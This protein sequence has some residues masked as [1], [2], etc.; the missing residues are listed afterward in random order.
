MTPPFVGGVAVLT[1]RT[2]PAL[3]SHLLFLFFGS[4]PDK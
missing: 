3:T 2:G 4:S 1:G